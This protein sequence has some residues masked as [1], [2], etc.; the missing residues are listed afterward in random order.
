VCVRFKAE[1]VPLDPDCSFGAKSG[2]P[3]A[4][5]ALAV[6]C[7]DPVLEIQHPKAAIKDTPLTPAAPDVINFYQE[8]IW[9]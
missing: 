3:V 6:I 1:R 8:L 7:H 4:G 2:A 5:Y 9:N